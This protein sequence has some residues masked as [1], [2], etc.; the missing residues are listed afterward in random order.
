MIESLK[1][2]QVL[3]ERMKVITDVLGEGLLFFDNDGKVLFANPGAL[4]LMEYQ[5]EEIESLNAINF[6]HISTSGENLFQGSISKGLDYNENDGVQK[7]GKEVLL[8][9]ILC[10]IDHFKQ[11]NDQSGHPACDKI[12]KRLAKLV[13]A[14]IRSIDFFARWGGEEFVILSPG[15][16]SKGAALLVDKTR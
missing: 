13:S 16:D 6:F 8:S 3:E 2:K 10:D 11:V 12:L 9:L 1:E 15:T 14:N 7:S 5:F 4:T